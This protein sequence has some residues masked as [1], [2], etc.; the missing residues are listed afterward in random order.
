MSPLFLNRLA[1]E[2]TY[3][4]VCRGSFTRD[5]VDAFGLGWDSSVIV[6]GK[7]R[8]EFSRK[9][10]DY[11]ES[12]LVNLDRYEQLTVEGALEE[13]FLLHHYC[14]EESE[15]RERGENAY[16]VPPYVWAT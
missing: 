5:G 6:D 14:L 13:V 10:K 16:T 4:T 8:E 7:R 12:E 1:S 11:A 2:T 9:T 15:F 3:C